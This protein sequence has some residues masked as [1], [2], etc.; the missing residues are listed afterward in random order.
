MLVIVLL[1]SFFLLLFIAVLHCLPETG[2][3]WYG[4]ETANRMGWKHR[5]CIMMSRT[6]FRLVILYHGASK[7]LMISI[8]VGIPASL[9][10]VIN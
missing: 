1:V 3:R 2:N 5:W 6:S 10:I 8:P 4:W 7:N 9:I